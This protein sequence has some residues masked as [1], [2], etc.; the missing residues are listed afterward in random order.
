[1]DDKTIHAREVASGKRFRF[2]SNWR[3]FL[4]SL[5]DERIKFAEDSLK[6]M[7]ETPDLIGKSFVDV[8]SGS[9]LFSLAARRLGA[10]V[11]SFDFDTQSFECTKEL[12]RRFFAD[13]PEWTV[14]QASA[15]DANYLRTLG[16]FDIV[17]SWGVLHHTGRMWDAL[18]KVSGLVDEGGKFFVSIYNDQGIASRFWTAVKKTYNKSPKFIKFI[19]VASVWA[20]WELRAAL[21][22]CLRFENPLPFNAWKQL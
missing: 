15:L 11:H 9:G 12:K 17:Y 8:G 19:M 2:G 10:R 7:L 18:D 21:A 6:K 4:A 3:Q 1:M 13:D 5:N 22:R 14:E 16:K 20:F